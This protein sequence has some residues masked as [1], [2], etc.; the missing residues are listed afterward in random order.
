VT[1]INRNDPNHAVCSEAAKSLPRGPLVTTWPCFTEAMYLLHRAG[2]YTA[3]AALW[4]LREAG[5]LAFHESAETEVV[6]MA[7]LMAKYYDLPMDLADASLIAAAERL[8]TRRV[9]T[10][11]RDFRVYRFEDGSAVEVIP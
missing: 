11:D 10:L 3:Q 4:Q 1:F 2:G 8:G 5:R 7:A 9:F 6:R